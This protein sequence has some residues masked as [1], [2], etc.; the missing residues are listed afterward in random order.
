MFGRPVERLSEQRHRPG[1]RLEQ[2]QDHADDGRL[3]CS[4]WSKEAVGLARVNLQVDASHS[5][6]VTEG[7][8]EF[9]CAENRLVG[10]IRLLFNRCSAYRIPYA[11]AQV[12]RQRKDSGINFRWSDQFSFWAAPMRTGSLWKTL[13]SK[14]GQESERRSC[15]PPSRSKESNSLE[16]EGSQVEPSLLVSV[17]CLGHEIGVDQ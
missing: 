14:K 6:D 17:T 4:I 13:I 5:L 8:P 15:F 10:H 1:G 2:P 16:E 9:V 3:A 7:F 12:N 11:E